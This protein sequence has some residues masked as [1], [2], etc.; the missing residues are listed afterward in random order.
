MARK[1]KKLPRSSAGN[2]TTDVACA[3][4]NLEADQ[5]LG[6]TIT[7]TLWKRHKLFALLLPKRL[8][9]QRDEEALTIVSA[10]ANHWVIA[11]A[12]AAL[13]LG[14]VLSHVI[15]PGVR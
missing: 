4:L 11:A 1:T 7:N 12:C 9:P 10:H 13:I 6:M 2:P 3:R 14:T 8:M 15:E 5:D